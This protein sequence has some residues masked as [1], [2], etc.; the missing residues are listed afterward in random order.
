M[1]FHWEI[2]VGC[3]DVLTLIYAICICD[4]QSSKREFVNLYHMILPLSQQHHE[5]VYFVCPMALP[6]HL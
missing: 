4:N 1:F 5:N 6:A 2:Q 3:R